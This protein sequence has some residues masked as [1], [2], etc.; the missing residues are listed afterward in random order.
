[1]H[2]V[3]NIATIGYFACSNLAGASLGQHG[4]ERKGLSGSLSTFQ[5]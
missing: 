4:T 2:A 3:I 5:K 1:M